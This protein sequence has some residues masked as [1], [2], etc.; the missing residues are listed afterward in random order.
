MTTTTPRPTGHAHTAGSGVSFAHVL[1]SE[2]I[3]LR[4]LRSTAWCFAV[5]V[6]LLI[7]FALLFGSFASG[8]EGAPA[9]DEQQQSLT[10]SVATI[11]V[12][13]AQLVAAVLGALVITGE[14]GTGMIRST[15][16]AVPRRTPAL[17]AKV[18]LIGV[19]TF[20]V[21]AVALAVALLVSTPLLASS[22][23]EADL[24]DGRI[25]LSMIGGAA[26]IGFI[27][28]IAFGLGAII[29][30]GAGAIA[31]AIGIVFVLPI[32]FSI[33]QALIA[34][35]WIYSLYEFIPP[36]A[37]SR[38]YDYPVDGQSLT[39]MPSFDGSLVLEPWQA[40]LVLVGWVVVLFAIALALVKR[41]DV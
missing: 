21:S 34:K 10:V 30:N 32:I 29:R 14:Y 40:L 18:L 22:D 25:W 16:T 2:W 9:T 15:F 31:S 5:I 20:V 13:F 37:A 19:S 7:G 27:A 8:F 38:V 4:S 41:R 33:G 11:G 28:M 23:V 24:G 26:T 39:A 1:R 36:Q 12:P 35:S 6:V 3:K 17:V